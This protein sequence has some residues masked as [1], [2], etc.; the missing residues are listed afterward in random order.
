MPVSLDAKTSEVNH[1]FFLKHTFENDTAK[2]ACK[3][4]IKMKKL[5]ENL[6]A[7]LYPVW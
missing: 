3:F 4:I 6:F 1:Y 7:K 5:F 2:F